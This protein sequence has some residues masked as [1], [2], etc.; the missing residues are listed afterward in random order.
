MQELGGV[1][2]RCLESPTQ[3]QYASNETRQASSS[4]STEPVARD[5]LFV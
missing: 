1:K 4:H 5:L 3:R 2:A